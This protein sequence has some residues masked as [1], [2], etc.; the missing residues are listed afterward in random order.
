MG[1]RAAPAERRN[2]LSRKPRSGGSDYA[3]YPASA[4]V[5]I[6][7]GTQPGETIADRV[8]EIEEIA[9]DL[10]RELPG[11]RAEV[12]V[13]LARDPFLAKGHER[14]LAAVDQASVAVLGSATEPAGVNAW[15]DAAL[16]QA[17][18]IPTLS[19]GA[20]GGNLHAPDEW[21]SIRELAA[22]TDILAGACESFCA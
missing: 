5:G 9:T 10:A 4:K 12:D 14:L 13:L 11:F 6:E 22:V 18:G 7:I 15:M 1:R 17:A 2:G 16:L 19:V 8:A 20:S 3:T 21:V